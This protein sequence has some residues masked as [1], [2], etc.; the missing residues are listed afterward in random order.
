MDLHNIRF[1]LSYKTIGEKNC[2]K[3]S[4]TKCLLLFH[5]R[6]WDPDAEND[7]VKKYRFVCL[8]AR[9][10]LLEK[11]FEKQVSVFFVTR[12]HRHAHPHTRTHALSCTHTHSVARTH[13]L[14]WP[15]TWKVDLNQLIDFQA[16]IVFNRHWLSESILRTKQTVVQGLD[17]TCSKTVWTSQIL[18]SKPGQ[19]RLLPGGPGWIIAEIKMEKRFLAELEPSDFNTLVVLGSPLSPTKAP[20]R[21][22][23][24]CAYGG[25]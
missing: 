7:E 25:H 24:F 15:Q 22:K 2:R 20:F 16:K 14:A 8:F 12:T 17:P 5:R 13:T 18:N 21:R 9:T 19:L 3:G 6:F 1:L 10:E 4:F 11:L 23:V